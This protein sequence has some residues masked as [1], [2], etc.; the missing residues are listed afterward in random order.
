MGY[1][2]SRKYFAVSKEP[3]KNSSAEDRVMACRFW[4]DQTIRTNN[5]TKKKDFCVK[6]AIL[7]ER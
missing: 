2:F 4:V 6:N 7:G 5:G 3:R 1:F